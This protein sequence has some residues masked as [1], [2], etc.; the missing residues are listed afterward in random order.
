MRGWA[1]ERIPCVHEVHE[2]RMIVSRGPKFPSRCLYAPPVPVAGCLDNGCALRFHHINLGISIAKVC[3]NHRDGPA[4]H[5]TPSTRRAIGTRH[6]SLVTMHQWKIKYKTQTQALPKRM[7]TCRQPRTLSC[8]A[9]HLISH[10][11]GLEEACTHVQ[12]PHELHQALGVD[13]TL[14]RVRGSE[15]VPGHSSCGSTQGWLVNYNMQ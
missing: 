3:D 2:S 12:Q 15:A 11:G 6:G 10:A 7:L 5:H 14:V 9:T 4:L 8:A 1:C 13:A